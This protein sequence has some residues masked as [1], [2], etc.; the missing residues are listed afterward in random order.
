VTD[1][2]NTQPINLTEAQWQQIQAFG[3]QA[4]ASIATA[5]AEIGDG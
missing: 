5:A 2:T 4:L 3:T 1:F